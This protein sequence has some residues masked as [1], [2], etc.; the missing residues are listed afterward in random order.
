MSGS[1][2]DATFGAPRPGTEALTTE[3]VLG[4]CRRAAFAAAT[5]GVLA[6]TPATSDIQIIIRNGSE[7]ATRHSGTRGRGTMDTPGDE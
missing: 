2:R 7:R 4:A 6:S 3:G 5:S 1:V